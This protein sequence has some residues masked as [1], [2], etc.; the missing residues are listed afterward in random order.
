MCGRA[1]TWTARWFERAKIACGHVYP[2]KFL[3]LFR[4]SAS[5]EE[6]DLQSIT[7]S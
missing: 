3:P 1:G 4:S 6:Q 5:T 2:V 7:E